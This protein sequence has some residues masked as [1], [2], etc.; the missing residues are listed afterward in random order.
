MSK[1]ALET[2][3]WPHF[4]PP[5]PAISPGLIHPPPPL[6]HTIGYNYSPTPRYPSS[7]V[8]QY[9][10]P[11]GMGFLYE[12]YCFHEVLLYVLG[13]FIIHCEHE[14]SVQVGVARWDTC[15][16]CQDVGYGVVWEGTRVLCREDIGHEEACWWRED[17]MDVPGILSE[18]IGIR[19]ILSILLR[20]FHVLLC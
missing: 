4:G 3:V 15:G 19:E 1:L 14:V 9:L 12:L 2:Q 7:T 8:H 13:I 11:W 10:T 17:L 6:P 16:N 5:L 20:T 18:V